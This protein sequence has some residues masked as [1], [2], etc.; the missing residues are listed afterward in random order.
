[1]SKKR[2]CRE[3]ECMA[4]G[5]FEACPAH[6]RCPDCGGPSRA[7]GRRCKACSEVRHKA[8]KNA[9]RAALVA[10]R[11]LNRTDGGRRRVPGSGIL[12]WAQEHALQEQPVAPVVDTSGCAHHDIVD[13]P[14][15]TPMSHAVCQKCGR[16]RDYPNY[17]D[18]TDWVGQ[19]EMT[20]AGRNG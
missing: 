12:T 14:S 7:Y 3:P 18:F 9:A 16:E 15:G 5:Q 2:Q 17:V 1:M 20:A 6:R 11:R 8:Q 19:T 10:A 4:K 13:T